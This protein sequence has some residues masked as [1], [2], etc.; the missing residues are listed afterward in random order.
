MSDSNHNLWAKPKPG[1]KSALDELT[2]DDFNT[3]AIDP[4]SF[5]KRK[6]QRKLEPY[7]KRL[8]YNHYYG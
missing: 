7:K 8:K 1:A 4:G 2:Q 5:D 3:D 6:L